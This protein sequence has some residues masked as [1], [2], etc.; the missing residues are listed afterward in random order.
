MDISQIQLLDELSIYH[1]HFI[2][3]SDILFGLKHIWTCLYT[4]TQ[5]FK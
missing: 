2:I 3:F 5:G 1:K 4:Q